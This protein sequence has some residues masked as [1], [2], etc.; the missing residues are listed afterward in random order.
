[1]KSCSRFAFLG[2]LT[3][4]AGLARRYRGLDRRLPD[5]S[6]VMRDSYRELIEKASAPGSAVSSITAKMSIFR[7]NFSELRHSKA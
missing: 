2:R 4:S 7:G 1:M 3:P 5:L 6:H